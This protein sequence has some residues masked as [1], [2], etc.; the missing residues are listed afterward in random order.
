MNGKRADIQIARKM[1]QAERTIWNSAA[2]HPHPIQ[3]RNVPA[4]ILNSTDSIC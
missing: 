1:A 2:P 3:M 4:V